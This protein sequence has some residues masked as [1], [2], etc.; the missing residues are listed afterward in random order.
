M[1][2]MM[3]AGNQARL[4]EGIFKGVRT[5]TS[6]IVMEMDMPPTCTEALILQQLQNFC[7]Y[8]YQYAVLCS[9]Q[10]TKS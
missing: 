2:V 1:A 3:V 10:E 9:E 8:S 4:P 7:I 5:L 6:N